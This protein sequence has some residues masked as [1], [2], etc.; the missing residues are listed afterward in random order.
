MRAALELS[1][2]NNGYLAGSTD[3]FLECETI[4]PGL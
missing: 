1:A 4:H 2:R 3:R